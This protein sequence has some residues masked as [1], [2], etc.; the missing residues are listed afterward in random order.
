MP[1]LCRF[2]GIVITMYP[3]DHPPPHFHARNGGRVAVFDLEGE[4]IIG[5]LPGPALRRVQRWARLHRDELQACWDRAVDRM[6]PGTIEP[7]R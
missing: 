7:L 1:E 3:D 6:D 5:W 2:F 4:V